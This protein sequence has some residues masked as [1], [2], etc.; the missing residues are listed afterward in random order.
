MHFQRFYLCKSIIDESDSPDIF[1]PTDQRPNLLGLILLESFCR[2]G[3]HFIQ[4]CVKLCLR[5]LVSNRDIIVQV[6]FF[7]VLRS[8]CA[9]RYIRSSI[10][11][12]SPVARR[13]SGNARASKQGVFRTSRPIRTV[14][15]PGTRWHYTFRRHTGSNLQ[16]QADCGMNINKLSHDGKL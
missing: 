8:A 11:F 12:I 4:S 7:L 14:S 3:K 13:F 5:Q 6:D 10:A 1:E 2:S 9:W 16:S 15:T